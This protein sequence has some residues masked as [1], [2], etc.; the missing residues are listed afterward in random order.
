MIGGRYLKHFK[1]IFWLP[2]WIKGTVACGKRNWSRL[3]LYWCFPTAGALLC[4]WQSRPNNKIGHEQNASNSSIHLFFTWHLKIGYIGY[5]STSSNCFTLFYYLSLPIFLHQ[6]KKQNSKP[7]SPA[8]PTRCSWN[9]WFTSP[10]SALVCSEAQPV[11]AR[12]PASPISMVG[13]WNHWNPSH[14]LYKSQNLLKRSP[15]VHQKYI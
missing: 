8:S 1:T 7:R 14:I 13:S 4:H 12:T 2:W 15:W 9:C 6:K 10:T 11:K 3:L 5:H